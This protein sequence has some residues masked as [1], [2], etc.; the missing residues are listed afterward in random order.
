MSS[1]TQ[2]VQNFNHQGIPSPDILDQLDLIEFEAT[3]HWGQFE[4]LTLEAQR[5]LECYDATVA[6]RRELARQV[7]DALCAGQAVTA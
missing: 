7:S 2:E 4:E 1:I 3:Y 5:H 6:Q